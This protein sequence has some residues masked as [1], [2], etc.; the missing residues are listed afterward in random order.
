MKIPYTISQNAIEA[1]GPSSETTELISEAARRILAEDFKWDKQ[2]C[3]SLQELCLRALAK[4]FKK[5]PLLKQLPCQNRIFLLDIL[6]LQLP[7]ELTIPV[8]HEERYWERRYTKVF[9]YT[10]RR[11]PE[12]WTWKGL[13]LERH[14]QQLMEQ[15]QPQYNDEEAMDEILTLCS[16]YVSRLF[17]EQLQS[18]KPPLTMKKEDIPE[19]WPIDHINLLPV[20]KKLNKIQELDIIFGVKNAGED[21]RFE[22]FKLSLQDGQ[23]LGKA[24]QELPKIQSLR[25]HRSSLEFEHCQALVQGLVNSKWSSL[26]ELDLSHCLIGNPGALCVA[27]LLQKFPGLKILNLTNNGIGKIGTEGLGFALLQNPGL[28]DLNLRLNPLG[29]D[30]TMGILSALVRISWPQRLSMAACMFDEDTALKVAQMIKLNDALERLDVSANYFGEA[31]G[32]ALVDA[33]E[34]NSTIQW[35]DVRET[36]ISPQQKEQVEECLLRNREEAL[37]R[38]QAE[39][40]GNNQEQEAETFTFEYE[41]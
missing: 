38:K 37:K 30:G 39:M 13:Y 9:K 31:V 17:I 5:T 36:D 3:P 15:A 19:V 28:Q 7:L 14:C 40:E 25:I 33:V 4:H 29:I 10:L 20:F 1:Y 8:I 11:K 26:V 23:R 41:Q 24:V 35:L 27:F 2:R 22:M 18:W 34:S 21:F 16:P 12:G 32:E 6:S